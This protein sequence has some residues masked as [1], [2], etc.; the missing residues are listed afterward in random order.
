MSDWVCCKTLLIVVTAFLVSGESGKDGVCK[1]KRNQALTIHR[2]RKIGNQS[3][4]VTYTVITVF[5]LIMTHSLIM[6]LLIISG[7]ESNPGPGNQ[8]LKR[9]IYEILKISY[10]DSIKTNSDKVKQALLGDEF[11]GLK[12]LIIE[13]SGL[14]TCPVSQQRM[15]MGFNPE[16]GLLENLGTDS[17]IRINT[18]L[19]LEKEDMFKKLC[20]PKILNDID[21]LNKMSVDEL[22]VV[23]S[24]R[25]SGDIETR[26]I[27]DVSESYNGS[28][29]D[30]DWWKGSKEGSRTRSSFGD[31]FDKLSSYSDRK[32][33]SS[34]PLTITYKRSRFS[35]IKS[36][37]PPVTKIDNEFLK[38]WR[39]CKYSEYDGSILNLLIGLTERFVQPGQDIKNI[40]DGFSGTIISSTL[41]NKMLSMSKSKK[42]GFVDDSGGVRELKH[43][44]RTDSVGSNGGSDLFVIPLDDYDLIIL[45]TLSKYGGKT[46]PSLSEIDLLSKEQKLSYLKTVCMPSDV[47]M[48]IN[49]FGETFKELGIDELMLNNIYNMIV[50]KIWGTSM[51]ECLGLVT[52]THIGQSKSINDELS[53]FHPYVLVANL[54]DRIMGQKSKND[55]LISMTCDN[56]N[57]V[58]AYL[59]KQYEDAELGKTLD[60]LSEILIKW[61]EAISGDKDSYVRSVAKL[62]KHMTSITPR[63]GGVG[64]VIGVSKLVGSMKS[65]ENIEIRRGIEVSKEVR[66]VKLGID[67]IFNKES[68]NSLI[69]FCIENGSPVQSSLHDLLNKLDN[70]L[71]NIFNDR[72]DMSK[73]V[74]TIIEGCRS[75]ITK[76]SLLLTDIEFSLDTISKKMSKSIGETE[77]LN[78]NIPEIETIQYINNL[79]KKASAFSRIKG[80][81]NE[82]LLC[83]ILEIEPLL[84]SKSLRDILFEVM[85]NVNLSYV[86]KPIDIELN[87]SPDGYMCVPSSII[88]DFLN[89][90]NNSLG[91]GFEKAKLDNYV[92]E[93]KELRVPHINISVKKDWENL[94]VLKDSEMSCVKGTTLVIFEF[95]HRNKNPEKKISTDVSKYVHLG[96]ISKHIMP[97]VLITVVV[98]PTEHNI[99]QDIGLKESLFIRNMKMC[100]SAVNLCYIDDI[101]GESDGSNEEQISNLYSRLSIP[102]ISTDQMKINMSG[103][104]FG[105]GEGIQNQVIP[106]VI[107]SCLMKS[108]RLG[109]QNAQLISDIG[110]E[111]FVNMIVSKLNEHGERTDLIQFSPLKVNVDMSSDDICKAFF[112]GLTS[113]SSSWI[114]C[115]CD[116][117]VLK[118]LYCGKDKIK[119]QRLKDTFSTNP[120]LRLRDQLS[121]LIGTYSIQDLINELTNDDDDGI[122]ISSLD[123]YMIPLDNRDEI[124]REEIPEHVKILKSVMW[125]IDL[126]KVNIISSETHEVNHAQRMIKPKYQKLDEQV[127]KD[128]CLYQIICSFMDSDLTY[129]CL[130]KNAVIKNFNV[131][132]PMLL[133]TTMKKIGFKLTAE[134]EREISKLASSDANA[135]GKKDQF[136]TLKMM[137]EIIHLRNSYK[138]RMEKLMESKNKTIDDVLENIMQATEDGIVPITFDKEFEIIIDNKVDPNIDVKS[139]MS[140]LY[141]LLSL[142]HK[143]DKVKDLYEP[144]ELMERLTS[145][146]KPKEIVVDRLKSMVK[147]QTKFKRYVNI[148]EFKIGHLLN[149][150]LDL[151]STEFSILVDKFWENF[152]N[153]SGIITPNS[154]KLETVL[155]NKLII[156]FCHSTAIIDDLIVFS[157]IASRLVRLTDFKKNNKASFHRIMLTEN[158]SMNV[159]L[160]KKTSTLFKVFLSAQSNTGN[161]VNNS[162][163][164]I[165]ESTFLPIMNA[166]YYYLFYFE[167]LIRKKFP[168]LISIDKIDSL[169]NQDILESEIVSSVVWLNELVELMGNMRKDIVTTS[170]KLMALLTDN[171]EATSVMSQLCFHAMFMKTISI[172]AICVNDKS[173][174]TVTQNMRYVFMAKLSDQFSPEGLGKKMQEFSRSLECNFHIRFMQLLSCAILQK[175]LKRDSVL[176]KKAIFS[177]DVFIDPV[178]L[179]VC[180]NEDDFISA[181]YNNHGYVRGIMSSQSNAN[182]HN[183]FFDIPLTSMDD[184]VRTFSQAASCCVD[185]FSEEYIIRNELCDNCRANMDKYCRISQIQI[186]KF[187]NQSDIMQFMSKS[188]ELSLTN[189]IKGTF[190]CPYFQEMVGKISQDNYREDDILRVNNDVELRSIPRTDLLQSTSIVSQFNVNFNPS[191]AQSKISQR[192]HS[193]LFKGL[194]SGQSIISDDAIDEVERLMESRGIHVRNLIENIRSGIMPHVKINEK[195]PSEIDTGDSNVNFTS[196]ADVLLQEETS[197]SA[198][199]LIGKWIIWSIDSITDV[200]ETKIYE[201]P[202]KLDVIS[203][204][205]SVEAKIIVT[206]ENVSEQ[207][208]ATSHDISKSRMDEYENMIKNDYGERIGLSGKSVNQIKRRLNKR[209]ADSNDKLYSMSRFKTMMIKFGNFIVSGAT[210]ATDFES[211]RKKELSLIDNLLTEA[212]YLEIDDVFTSFGFNTEEYGELNQMSSIE[213]EIYLPKEIGPTADGYDSMLK[214]TKFSTFSEMIN[215]SDKN[216]FDNTC[217]AL[218]KEI[219]EALLYTD[220]ESHRQGL[221]SVS[222]LQREHFEEQI[223]FI[224]S[225]IKTLMDYYPE[226][227]L[228]YTI[229]VLR[230]V[231]KFPVSIMFPNHYMSIYDTNGYKEFCKFNLFKDIE[232]QHIVSCM[233]FCYGDTLGESIIRSKNLKITDPD[234]KDIILLTTPVID[235]EF[236]I[237]PVIPVLDAAFRLGDS[238]LAMMRMSRNGVKVKKTSVINIKSD[239]VVFEL[240]SNISSSGIP[241]LWDSVATH[242]SHEISFVQKIAAK[243]QF[244]GERDL[245]VQDLKTKE[246]MALLERVSKQFLSVSSNDILVHPNKKKDVIM[247]ISDMIGKVL[248]GEETPNIS[249]FSSDETKWGPTHNAMGFLNTLKRLFS[250][251]RNYYNLLVNCCILNI[252]KKVLINPRMIES[253][254]SFITSHNI[255]I[256]GV[257][258]G[259]YSLANSSGKPIGLKES[260]MLISSMAEGADSILYNC[261]MRGLTYMSSFTHMGQGIF[262]A[263]SS[264][265]ADCYVRFSNVAKQLISRKHIKVMGNPISP[266][267][268]MKTLR[269]SDD[270]ITIAQ[271]RTIPKREFI[272]G[273]RTLYYMNTAICHT[274]N[275]R[276]SVKHMGGLDA[277]IGEVYSTFT[278]DKTMIPS[279]K[280][281]MAILTAP[282]SSTL[283]NTALMRYNLSRSCIENSAKLTD[284]VFA[285][286]LAY[287][288]DTLVHPKS[289]CSVWCGQAFPMCYSSRPDISMKS[290]FSDPFSSEL[291]KITEQIRLVLYKFTENEILKTENSAF[292]VRSFSEGDVEM[293]QIM[294]K[295]I[296]ASKREG[297]DLDI[298]LHSALCCGL[299][300]GEVFD[301]AHDVRRSIRVKESGIYSDVQSVPQSRR[302][303]QKFNEVR[304]AVSN[305][306]SQDKTVIMDLIELAST[307]VIP[308]TLDTVIIKASQS[309]RNQD[310]NTQRSLNPINAFN[311][312]VHGVL[313]WY[314]N[315][316]P[317]IDCPRAM[318]TSGFS[319]TSASKS[320]MWKV[321]QSKIS[322]KEN[323]LKFLS[324]H[325]YLASLRSYITPFNLRLNE[326]E[327]NSSMNGFKSDYLVNGWR[328]LSKTVK[329]ATISSDYNLLCSFLID[330]VI[331]TLQG[332][333]IPFRIVMSDL[334]S[335]SNKNLN[336][337]SLP[338][339]A[340]VIYNASRMENDLISEKNVKENAVEEMKS[341][342]QKYEILIKND[343]INLSVN[344]SSNIINYEEATSNCELFNQVLTII[345]HWSDLISSSKKQFNPLYIEVSNEKSQSTEE[346]LVYH[347]LSQTFNYDVKDVKQVRNYGGSKQLIVAQREAELLTMISIGSISVELEHEN[348]IQRIL[349]SINEIKSL[350]QNEEFVSYEVKNFFQFSRPSYIGTKILSVES[351]QS[352]GQTAF[353]YKNRRTT[354]IVML[355]TSTM[356]DQSYLISEDPLILS[357]ALEQIE[358]YIQQIKFKRSYKE[359]MLKLNTKSFNKGVHSKEIPLIED[360]SGNF[361]PTT[362]SLS[363]DGTYRYALISGIYRSLEPMSQIILNKSNKY[364]LSKNR[365]T[366]VTEMVTDKLGTIVADR[367]TIGSFKESGELSVSKRELFGSQTFRRSDVVA[368][369]ETLGKIKLR[370][371]RESALNFFER[372]ITKTNDEKEILELIS[373]IKGSENQLRSNGTELFVPGGKDYR[374]TV[375][376]FISVIDLIY[377][378]DNSTLNYNSLGIF[379]NLIPVDYSKLR[380]KM[381]K[382]FGSRQVLWNSITHLR[383]LC[384]NIVGLSDAPKSLPEGMSMM[385]SIMSKKEIML[386]CPISEIK[387]II[388]SYTFP[389]ELKEMSEK[390]ELI[391]RGNDT[392]KINKRITKIFSSILFYEL[393]SIH[394]RCE[395]KKHNETGEYMTVMKTDKINSDIT[396]LFFTGM[397]RIINRSI[398]SLF[399]EFIELYH[400]ITNLCRRDVTYY[401]E[402]V[403]KRESIDTIDISNRVNVSRLESIPEE[404]DSGSTLYSVSSIDE[405]IMEGGDV[406]DD[407]EYI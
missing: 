210:S 392:L 354:G 102:L 143:E 327:T 42:V 122:R 273:V 319:L 85:P 405:D 14:I 357:D 35:N 1:I 205:S 83:N 278:T 69:Q 160:P 300:P 404:E 144:K 146:K 368:I 268:E 131:R 217:G 316:P 168:E 382:V 132:D 303:I 37:N 301:M 49:D 155:I 145:N 283:L 311:Q 65:S 332:H 312:S 388:S 190:G 369:M 341:L 153:N 292:D 378:R 172:P 393:K 120:S 183:A 96:L 29:S 88:N 221:F 178:M 197:S 199:K 77:E 295:M 28:G 360:K 318:L 284:V 43:I 348:I 248:S 171:L 381:D 193:S 294:E 27:S 164:N 246:V 391:I 95:G 45:W 395:L 2:R 370:P 142:Y 20:N 227:I 156:K 215:E 373:S 128:T 235:S 80:I 306:L 259:K 26:S 13:N 402:S 367:T 261:I 249:I 245:V 394:L 32:K 64:S 161:E 89:Y 209:I 6:M 126:M 339:I 140:V 330:D 265:S 361:I 365:L 313:G 133:K 66:N 229:D 237:F 342:F 387:A 375:S 100:D 135:H 136:S 302:S 121:E 240:S 5:S 166:P 91:D 225:Q 52:K 112:I 10:G 262:H 206:G 363:R 191:K 151:R 266:D 184:L 276:K 211:D 340:K 187:E 90:E 81:I 84:S 115:D 325:Q 56:I 324:F 322:T 274:M 124:E 287:S 33:S 213:K 362:G 406:F 234:I 285:N 71:L 346:D 241:L 281:L 41:S 384:L 159:V 9:S 174:N 352:H 54:I 298:E 170:S 12:R 162:P 349:T 86:P 53:A 154:L 407:E 385:H 22:E 101:S 104:R 376:M 220:D 123:N 198:V 264:L 117:D 15:T 62:K 50:Y 202:T 51:S 192:M 290:L 63:S 244:G 289:S 60:D 92:K 309:V 68:V 40:V 25:S 371:I 75:R 212:T 47:F 293:S 321:N 399:N 315:V 72:N 125:G 79:K 329:S 188:F 118:S 3:F 186:Y 397:V 176:D 258:N 353:I 138:R 251:N 200:D 320:L 255:K 275:M 58:K 250:V 390:Y 204:L 343:L 152:T 379:I 338:M 21:E 356:G 272:S 181:I 228:K 359:I 305:Q 350:D 401:P 355:S 270:S 127:K 336:L 55:F 17:L 39:E 87:N 78:K 139:S 224:D 185:E 147:R 59:Q 233:I 18:D 24:Q 358:Q 109:N 308:K 98:S 288:R 242:L 286:T 38:K 163:I 377:R 116:V 398:Y 282:P 347:N 351:Y 344:D 243:A 317:Y 149:I 180:K 70:V 23:K 291:D 372:K 267:I 277:I 107:Q 31:S 165:D 129:I 195:L 337:I 232:D 208:K 114:E 260:G 94:M 105:N 4:V 8:G 239:R 386:I 231:A 310:P 97:I 252:S 403:I 74:Q 173:H 108:I 111:E 46:F 134:I 383:T 158:I 257:K 230:M 253:V 263:T 333:L 7:I 314:F 207:K 326:I 194:L 169:I 106:H 396:L 226:I 218:I 201:I 203:T 219:N 238:R 44:K 73:N 307:R 141:L 177:S 335:L 280:T 304:S 389:L 19:F 196:I 247:K 103:V 222:S 67:K 366:A 167:K 345:K 296:N 57:Q 113:E 380:M 214:L 223:K 99:I 148:N 11:I 179:S 271:S 30:Y 82:I 157:T 189:N 334:S 400:F 150:P 279:I 130:G 297:D 236:L 48:N 331:I 299:R 76:I 16:T 137:Y 93:M 216:T 328:S 374:K 182:V 323:M 364:L 61:E 119:S 34:P 256:N 175:K 110:D 36:S 254:L 269:S